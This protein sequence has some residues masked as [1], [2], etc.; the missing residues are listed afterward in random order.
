M[1]ERANR[2][3]YPV[4]VAAGVF[5]G[6]LILVG[7]WLG[8]RSTSADEA[9][10]AA[11]ASKSR[12]PNP[13]ASLG[14]GGSTGWSALRPGA[15]ASAPDPQADPGQTATSIIVPRPRRLGGDQPVSPSTTEL[16]DR[17]GLAPTDLGALAEQPGGD[18]P[19]NIIRQLDDAH[20]QGAAL[21]DRLGL[22]PPERDLLAGR[23]ANQLVR[24]ERQ[25]EKSPQPVKF[26]DVQ[27][28]VTH[29]TLE[30]LRRNLGDDVAHA[31]EQDV[32]GLQPLRPHP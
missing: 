18:L 12:S 5:A 26:E 29:D 10:S 6:L 30:D 20:T 9:A 21:G 25:L 13:A 17:L 19:P 11:A 24:L 31:A 4:W 16:A 14:R 32:R 1:S 27:E 28:M 15:S 7:Y 23:F 2:G 3:R 22:A 8:R